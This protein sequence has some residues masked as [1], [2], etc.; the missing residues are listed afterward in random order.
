MPSGRKSMQKLDER[1]TRM[2]LVVPSDLKDRIEGWCRQQ[3]ERTT[4]S[5]AVRTLLEVGL[6]NAGKGGRR[7][8]RRRAGGNPRSKVRAEHQ[9]G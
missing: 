7:S 8:E 4:V 2:N 3:R 5:E 9:P 6:E 1:I